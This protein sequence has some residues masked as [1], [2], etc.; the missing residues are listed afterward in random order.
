MQKRHLITSAL[1]LI[2]MAA[3]TDAT[4][5]ASDVGTGVAPDDL[6]GTWTATS[7]VFTSLEHPEL[8]ANVVAEGATMTL[9]LRADGTFSW[10]YVFPGEPTESDTGTYTVSGGT[11][12]L[13][14]TT[15]SETI[16]ITWN[17]NTMTLTMADVFDFNPGM[18]EPARLVISLT[19]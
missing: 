15:G 8:S 19:R 17:G 12:T 11:M 18:E 10:T 14:E 16:A 5:V 13:F 4:G 1:A 2:L 3:C 9:T 7:M 6:A